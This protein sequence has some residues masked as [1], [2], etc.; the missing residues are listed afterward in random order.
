M[1]L[2]RQD[3][4]AGGIVHPDHLAAREGGLASL[5]ATLRPSLRSGCRRCTTLGVDPLEFAG[6]SGSRRTKPQHALHLFGRD[7]RKVIQKLCDREPIAE[8]IK[9]RLHRYARVAEADLSAHAGRIAPHSSI[10]AELV[11]SR[12]HA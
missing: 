12:A 10:P 7:G 3:H 9:E 6:R 11:L 1:L 8:R 4:G 2:P 5:V